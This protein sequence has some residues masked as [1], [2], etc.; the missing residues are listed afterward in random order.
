MSGISVVQCDVAVVLQC[1]CSVLQCVSRDEWN[2]CG[3]VC[4]SV[5]AM[6]LQ[7]RCSI[8]AVCCSV[9]VGMSGKSVVQYV[10]VLLQCCRS[11]LN[12]VADS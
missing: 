10:A 6:L 2:K 7:Y 9:L 11:V 8:V 3:A 4:C 1:C 5:V 12:C